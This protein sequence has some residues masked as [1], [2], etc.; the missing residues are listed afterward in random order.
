[1]WFTLNRPLHV[2]D[3]VWNMLPETTTHSS[4]VM[5]YDYLKVRYPNLAV[6]IHVSAR[7]AY[8]NLDVGQRTLILME[9]ITSHASGKDVKVSMKNQA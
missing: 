8:P 6:S 3:A 7:L 2:T 4:R 5:S 9:E 1:M